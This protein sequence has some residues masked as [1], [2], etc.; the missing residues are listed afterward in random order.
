MSR[1]DRILETES[2][3]EKTHLILSQWGKKGRISGDLGISSTGDPVVVLSNG[4]R[5]MLKNDGTYLFKLR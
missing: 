4:S 2:T 1:V 3:L 5:I